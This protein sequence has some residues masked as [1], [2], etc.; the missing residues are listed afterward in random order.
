MFILF[1]TNAHVDCFQT[2]FVNATNLSEGHYFGYYLR[3]RI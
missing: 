2:V 3:K 1:I